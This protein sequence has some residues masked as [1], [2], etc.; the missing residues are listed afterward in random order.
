MH[1][2][3]RLAGVLVGVIMAGVLFAWFLLS[4]SEHETA[5]AA[6][7]DLRVLVDEMRPERFYFFTY[8]VDV[9]GTVRV[10]VRRDSGGTIQAALD[11]CGKCF[12]YRLRNYDWRGKLI[13]RHCGYPMPLPDPQG[14][15]PPGK[16]CVPEA[17]PYSL[18]NGL[19]LVRGQVIVERARMLLATAGVPERAESEPEIV[20]R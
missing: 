17:L 2:P 6:G 3:L 13:C 10:V 20:G 19:L 15:V 9:P 12:P 7:S 11:S 18:E 14:P 4:G 16:G 8:P 1:H 5:L